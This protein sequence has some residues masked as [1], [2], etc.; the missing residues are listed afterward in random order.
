[1]HAV[2]VW[3]RKSL[4]PS[5]NGLTDKVKSNLLQFD[6]LMKIGLGVTALIILPDFVET[7]LK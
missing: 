4:G 2:A 1:M 3:R 6:Y 7:G 5:I